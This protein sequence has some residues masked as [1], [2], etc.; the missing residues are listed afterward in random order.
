MR[1]EKANPKIK[2]RKKMLQKQVKQKNIIR[3][4]LQILAISANM[5]MR[6]IKN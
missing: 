5:V 6:F 4:F 1:P 3:I 2:K